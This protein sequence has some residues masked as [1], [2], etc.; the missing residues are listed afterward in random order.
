MALP[1]KVTDVVAVQRGVPILGSEGIQIVDARQCVHCAV[2]LLVTVLVVRPPELRNIHGLSACPCAGNVASH[3][4]EEI[5]LEKEAALP[6]LQ[7]VD[8]HALPVPICP[9]SC[10][11][12][13]HHHVPL[14]PHGARPRSTICAS[15]Q[16]TPP[17][18]LCCAVHDQ[19]LPQCS[20]ALIWPPARHKCHAVRWHTRLVGVRGQHEQGGEGRLGCGAVQERTQLTRA[21]HVACQAYRTGDE[22]VDFYVA[23]VDHADVSV[24]PCSGRIVRED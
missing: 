22:A 4:R 15:H 24:R 14:K 11:L 20:L 10:V 21:L 6:G 13:V 1:V 5:R 9:P 3:E 16:H 2:R 12:R 17:P 7:V 8:L 19:L 18:L 23:L